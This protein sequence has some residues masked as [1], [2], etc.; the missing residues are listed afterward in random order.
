MSSE[1]ILPENMLAIY[2]VEAALGAALEGCSYRDIAKAFGCCRRTLIHIRQKYPLFE[3]A[4]TRA[5]DIGM[6]A[7]A[8]E[9]RHIVDDNLDLAPVMVRTKWEV[10]KWLLSVHDPAKYGDRLIVRE[11]K[12]DLA[13]ALTEAKTRVL[14]ITPK[15]NVDPFEE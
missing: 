12:V 15:S 11:E 7:F 8:D 2:D 3:D 9:Q 4:L 5:R 1:L 14:D 13:G 10:N 6:D